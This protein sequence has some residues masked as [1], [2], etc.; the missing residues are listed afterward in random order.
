MERQVV[1]PISAMFPEAERSKGTRHAEVQ[2]ELTI[3]PDG[4]VKDVRV[5]TSAGAEFDDAALVVGRL[6]VF[7]KYK[8]V[9]LQRFKVTFNLY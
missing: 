7:A 6:T 1:T 3:G 9:T 2:L 4:I 5:V 8:Q